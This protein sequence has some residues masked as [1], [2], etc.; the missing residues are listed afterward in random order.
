LF[1]HKFTASVEQKLLNIYGNAPND[2][3]CHRKPEIRRTNR[4]T[5]DV[6]GVTHVT[7]RVRLV[8]KFAFNWSGIYT[9]LGVGN[10]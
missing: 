10:G 5:L 1:H 6:T 3:S 9:G 4:I 7:C 8:S 2:K